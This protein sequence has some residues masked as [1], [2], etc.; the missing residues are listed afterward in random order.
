MTEMGLAES[1]RLW[2]VTALQSFP[3]RDDLKNLTIDI[4]GG[5]KS[6][7]S[8]REA[9]IADADQIRIGHLWIWTDRTTWNP[10]GGL[11]DVYSSD[12]YKNLVDAPIVNHPFSGL[13][14]PFRAAFETKTAGPK[15]TLDVPEDAVLWDAKADG[16]KPVGKGVQG[17]Q[18]SH[19][20]LQQI[21]PGPLPSRSEE[22]RRPIWSTR[23]RRPGRWP[24][25]RKSC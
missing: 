22:S 19:L 3:A 2:F 1:V 8:L 12:I 13:P 6:P 25:T 10:V 18:Q 11:S 9:S 21:F 16:W 15:G 5:P 14:V 20:R 4:V 17:G 24:T 23:W 7:L